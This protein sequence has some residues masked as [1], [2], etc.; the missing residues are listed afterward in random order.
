MLA[1]AGNNCGLDP[2]MPITPQIYRILREQI[3]RN[4]LKPGHRISEAEIARGYAVSR[5]PV[6]EAFIRLAAEGLIVVRPQRATVISRIAHAAVLDARFLREAIEADIVRLLAERPDPALVATLR[7]DL[8]RQKAAVAPQDF[9]RLDEAFHRSLAEGAGKGGA[10]RLIEGL[11]SQM[12]RVRCLSHE[13]FPVARLIAQHAALVERIAAGD[14][15]GA[16]AAIRHHLRELLADLPAIL[17][18]SP[19]FFDAPE[20]SDTPGAAVPA[21]ATSSGADAAER[22]GFRACNN[23]S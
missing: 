8:A 17:R 7:A 12:D 19:E 23:V 2:A 10:W 22:S 3:V 5:Q 16:E 18:A 14:V 1:E 4:D 13:H 6:R 15:P 11:K 21:P 9:I 20:F